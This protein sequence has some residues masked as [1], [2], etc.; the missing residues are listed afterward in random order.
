MKNSQKASRSPL[1][2]HAADVLRRA[3]KVPI[4]PAR[5]DLRQLA[6]ALLR[7]EK[8]GF[9]ATVY[10]GSTAVEHLRR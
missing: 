10:D 6:V 3:R 1:R 9:Q 2:T 7:L 8:V 5:N 4:G